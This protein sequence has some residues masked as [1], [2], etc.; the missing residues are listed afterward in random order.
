MK[1]WLIDWLILYCFASRLKIFIRAETS[2][3]PVKGCKLWLTLGAYG[4]CVS[5]WATIITGIKNKVNNLDRYSH[6]RNMLSIPYV[7]GQCCLHYKYYFTSQGLSP[8][9]VRTVWYHT[10]Y[11]KIHMVS[12][13]S[14]RGCGALVY[15]VD[16]TSGRRLIRVWNVDK[17]FILMHVYILIYYAI[18]VFC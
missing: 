6:N 12:Y 18:I 10:M 13:R 15:S 14:D 8:F 2:P 11:I 3:L 7:N 16:S 17:L 5:Y 1:I 9:W 4:H